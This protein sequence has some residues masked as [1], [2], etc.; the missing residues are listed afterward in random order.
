MLRCFFTIAALIVCFAPNQGIAQDARSANGAI[1]PAEELMRARKLQLES[2]Q[3]LQ[4]MNAFGNPGSE[5]TGMPMQVDPALQQAMEN[6]KPFLESKFAL[7]AAK[8]FQNPKF[9]NSIGEITKHPHRKNLLYV[10]GGWII[11]MMMIRAWRLSIPSHWATKIWTRMWTLAVFMAGASIV[12]P[13]AVFGE[14]YL[15][16]LRAIS[17][18]FKS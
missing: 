7:N 12:I 11:F 17:E 4:S 13:V 18:L 10:M 6:L 15:T 14:P 2:L 5:S 1:D 9:T 8:L 3:A 16:I